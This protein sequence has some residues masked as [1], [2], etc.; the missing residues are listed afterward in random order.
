MTVRLPDEL[1]ARIDEHAKGRGETRS[2]VMRR[3]LEAGLASESAAT[4]PRRSVK[5]K[6]ES[7]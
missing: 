6:D 1:T 2:E 7:Q 5:R 4:K 3:F